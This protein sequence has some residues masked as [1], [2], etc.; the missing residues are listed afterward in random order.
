MDD[1][2]IPEL[3]KGA[4]VS[5]KA[6]DAGLGSLTIELA[7]RVATGRPVDVDVSVLL[8]GSDG[9]VRTNEDFIFFNQP[10]AL[11]GAVRLH[12]KLQSEDGD[13]AVV[14]DFV[15]VELD[16]LPDDVHRIVLAG[17]IDAADSCFGDVSQLLMTV[18]RSTDATDLLRFAIGRLS[19]ERAL[20][21]G[22]IYRR[23][24]D[25]K[26]RAVGQGFDQGLAALVTEHG[27][28]V[29]ADPEPSTDAAT[30]PGPNER[31]HNSAT[32]ARIDSEPLA[33]PDVPDQTPAATAIHES[34]TRLSVRRVTRAPRLPADWAASV[35]GGSGA[36]EWQPA[37]LLPVAGIG[38]GEE[39]E[40]RATSAF[41]AVLAN[42]KEF[43]RAVLARL[44]A[45]TGSVEAFIEV[46]FGMD[47]D[48][49]RPDGVIRV[50][51]GGRQWTALVEVKTGDSPL[52]I[53]QVEQYLDIAASKKYDAVLTIS[54]QLTSQPSDHPLQLGAKR[55]KKIALLHLSWE[56]IRTDIALLQ[57]NQRVA[58]PTQNY[59]LRE[60]Q[61]YME[62]PRS[63]LHGFTD[64]GQHWVKI[65]ESA[66]AKTLRSKD[67]G[68][69][70]V[71]ARYDQLVNHVALRL[72]ALLGVPVV[73]TVPRNL[74]ENA[75]REAQ[76]ADS[77]LLFG[78][79]K[80]PGAV[81]AI[82]VQT[83]VRTELVT[84]S[85][86]IEAPREGRPLTRINWLLRQIPDARG[87]VRVE[88]ILSGGRARTTADLLDSVRAKPE[89]LAPA[90]GKEI[91]AFR[92][93][94]DVSMGG[95]RGAGKGGLIESVQSAATNFYAEVVQNLRAWSAKPPR[96]IPPDE[97]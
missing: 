81:D 12:E 34:G 60:F 71:I 84:C 27:V 5:L 79:I 32:N 50:T 69:A 46:T 53:G 77:G 38:S 51:R 83:E 3:S 20:I 82:V 16:Q 40:R 89:L 62:H 66:R 75:S 19:T 25:W 49:Y 76:L 28:E 30:A 92:L 47:D 88:A 86:Q 80:V 29:D 54:N 9:Q 1:S 56:Q 44:G 43:G 36:P 17:S 97:R 33:T 15:T 35:P 70:D 57:R 68:C 2:T 63:G 65:R 37:R 48:A 18:K 64:M 72:S 78:T 45:P 7:S 74:N 4:N 73:A 14:T 52:V 94:M 21:F 59:L 55:T 23:D 22:E 39:Q 91:R 42:V 10:T 13:Q 90:D 8:L 85:I 11:G 58:E 41:L 31:E 95:K 26:V 96:L 6:L 24:D 93:G 87:S 61:R 67:K